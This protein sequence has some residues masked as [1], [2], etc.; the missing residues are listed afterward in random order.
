M[1]DKT[2]GTPPIRLKRLDLQRI[3]RDHGLYNKSDFMDILE[4]R[5]S[6]SETSAKWRVEC[7]IIQS[8]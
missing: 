6:P 3:E 4:K 5:I 1:V 7:Q 8:R 2:I